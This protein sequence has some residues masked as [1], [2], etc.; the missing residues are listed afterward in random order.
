MGKYEPL[1]NYLQNMPSDKRDLTMS[2][3]ELEKVLNFKLPMSAHE[4]RAW[5][6][7]SS[8]REDHP[9]AQSWL[10][11]HWKVDSLSLAEK[12]VRFVRD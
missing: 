4:Y 12:W 7:N 6:A 10:Q 2:F 8:S 1:L 11:A 5:W 9:H 3:L